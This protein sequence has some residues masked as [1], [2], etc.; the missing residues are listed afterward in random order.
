MATGVELS[1]N[2]G[3]TVG[4]GIENKL[5]SVNQTVSAAS[6]TTTPSYVGEIVTDLAADANYVA[7]GTSANTD[8]AVTNKV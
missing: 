7:T 4:S 8:W 1:G 3:G 6:G 2:G 5:S